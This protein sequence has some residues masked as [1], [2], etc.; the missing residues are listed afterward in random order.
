MTCSYFNIVKVLNGKEY[1]VFVGDFNECEI[2]LE[3]LNVDIDLVAMRRGGLFPR[4]KIE[5]RQRRRLISGQNTL[6]L[7]G[8]WS[9]RGHR[10]ARWRLGCRCIGLLILTLWCGNAQLF[11]AIGP[12]NPDRPLA[13]Q[14][15]V[16]GRD[17][18]AC[19]RA[20]VTVDQKIAF[21]VVQI[22]V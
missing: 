9:R 1:F 3:E 13:C 12:Q 20:M 14:D 5:C 2:Y 11:I 19:L 16:I 6:G 4:C 15:L 7:R 8:G 22:P 10:H 18:N 17:M 21:I